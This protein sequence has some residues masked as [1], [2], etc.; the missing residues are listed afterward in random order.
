MRASREIWSA[1][2]Y[3]SERGREEGLQ[4]THNSLIISESAHRGGQS[5]SALFGDLLE[6]VE[7][8]DSQQETGTAADRECYEQS[9]ALQSV[10]HGLVPVGNRHVVVEVGGGAEAAGEAA[11][12]KESATA[13]R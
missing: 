6:K 7:K 9:I 12:G 13:S 11:E 1:R 2:E 8:E 10:T 3:G 5:R 4:A